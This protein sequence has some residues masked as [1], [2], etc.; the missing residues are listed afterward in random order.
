[1]K[2]K[3]PMQCCEELKYCIVNTTHPKIQIPMYLYRQ[4]FSILL[5]L[6]AY[7]RTASQVSQH[8]WAM[9]QD[10]RNVVYMI[11]KHKRYKSGMLDVVLT[12]DL[13]RW[14][15][16]LSL[17]KERVSER[18]CGCRA[19]STGAECLII[20]SKDASIACDL[21]SCRNIS[22]ARYLH[23]IKDQVKW[24]N[25][26]KNINISTSFFLARLSL[27]LN[28]YH[29]QKHMTKTDEMLDELDHFW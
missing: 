20:F 3:V 12:L 4:F 25:F 14:K 13:T 23:N 28:L 5:A 7:S 18:N 24:P 8:D 19:N 22:F 6:E 9:V 29:E 26:V 2:K 1:M 11:Y 16:L 15:I 17:L 21:V 27:R 10:A